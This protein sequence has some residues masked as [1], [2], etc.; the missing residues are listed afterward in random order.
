MAEFALKEYL[1]KY[2]IKNDPRKG[3]FPTILFHP[4]SNWTFFKA[5]LAGTCSTHNKS[6]NWLLFPQQSYSVLNS[7]FH[8]CMHAHPQTKS[9][10]LLLNQQK[11]IS[12]ENNVRE[13]AG[14]KVDLD[15]SLFRAWIWVIAACR[16]ERRERDELLN[17][18][19][20]SSTGTC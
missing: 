4:V 15:L 2:M 5:T 6:V 7:H 12:R 11:S 8:T 19:T 17:I 1:H 9:I 10:S 20:P 18:V 16:D 13:H 14:K 3:F